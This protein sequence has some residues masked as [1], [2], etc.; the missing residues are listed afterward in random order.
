VT[1]DPWLTA[2]NFLQKN[3][4]SPMFLDQVANFI[5]E[6]TKGHTLGAAAPSAADPFTGR[7]TEPSSY[8]ILAAT[9]LDS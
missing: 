4:L 5:I 7:A 9:F 1:D 6:N 2:H 3:E 8:Y